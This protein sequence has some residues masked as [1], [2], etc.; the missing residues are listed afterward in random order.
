MAKDSEVPQGLPYATSQRR[1]EIRRKHRRNNIVAAAVVATTILSVIA[2]AVVYFFP[3]FAVR[4]VEVHGVK[5]VSQ[6]KVQE[7]AQAPYG[8]SLLQVDARA[9]AQRVQ[10]IR[11]FA[12]VRVR[13]QYPSTVRIDVHE[14]VPAAVVFS[15]T[16]FVVYDKDGVD[17]TRGERPE[18]TLEVRNFSKEE[19]DVGQAVRDALSIAG[20]L[21][22]RANMVP[23]FVDMHSPSRYVVL[24]PEKYVLEWGSPTQH[25]EKAAAFTKV[26]DLGATHWNLANPRLPSSK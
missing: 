22:R 2:F 11:Q 26:A 20:A 6:E 25:E 9:I 1:Q 3:V 4:T 24:G 21:E 7:V 5:S 17:F 23:R 19:A 14:R 18:G 16:D 13:T 8:L 10:S 15:G 12:T